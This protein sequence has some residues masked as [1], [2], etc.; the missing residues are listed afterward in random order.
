MTVAS[1]LDPLWLLSCFGP[2]AVGVVVFAE[3]ALITEIVLPGES[4]LATAGMFSA[5]PASARWHLPLGWVIVCAALGACSGAQTGDRIGQRSGSALLARSRWAPLAAVHDRSARYLAHL[6]HG[7]AIVLARLVPA[8]RPVINPLARA[9]GVPQPVFTGGQV[10]GG[11]A[12]S[13]GGVL[14]G[15]ALGAQLT[16]IGRQLPLVIA[17]VIVVS[18]IPVGTELLHRRVRRRGGSPSIAA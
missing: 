16:G 4:L 8:I 6:G 3:S 18:A 13:I 10:A 15:Y 2:V 9:V 14:A 1:M 17:S 12:W 5:A 7:P 11:L